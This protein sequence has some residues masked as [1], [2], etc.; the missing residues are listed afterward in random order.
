VPRGFSS[1][2]QTPFIVSDPCLILRT[3]DLVISPC[4]VGRIWRFGKYCAKSIDNIRYCHYYCFIKLSQLVYLVKYRGLVVGASAE[5]GRSREAPRPW[6]KDRA[7]S[8][9]IASTGMMTRFSA[10]GARTIRIPKTAVRTIWTKCRACRAKRLYL[11]MFDQASAFERFRPDDE[12]IV[13]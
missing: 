3:Y 6:N 5:P 4:R 2:K 12:Q 8:V 9:E 10:T 7:R 13:E 1:R 11:L